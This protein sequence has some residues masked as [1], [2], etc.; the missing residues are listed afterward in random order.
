MDGSL[1]V[2]Y[3]NNKGGKKKDLPP[4][5]QEILIEKSVRDALKQDI[6]NTQESI[7]TE[8]R[9]RAEEREALRQ[10]Y[11]RQIEDRRRE[12]EEKRQDGENK[13]R[14][15]ETERSEIQRRCLE[16]I[17]RMEEDH[18]AEM[19]RREQDQ[20]EKREADA[21]R[22]NE[23]KAKKEQEVESFNGQYEQIEVSQAKKNE[24]LFNTHKLEKESL[25]EERKQLTLEL[26]RIIQE[27]KLTREEAEKANWDLIESIKEKNKET[28]AI[29]ID[30]GIK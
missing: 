13:C 30:K 4:F 5:S 28:Q 27:H 22:Y 7:N 16:D 1:A 17:A 23:L 24:D 14:K 3:I 20:L 19:E 15:L 18:K 11:S 2:F 26:E 9:N 6:R 8:N 25:E 12:I 29:E 21:N 10:K